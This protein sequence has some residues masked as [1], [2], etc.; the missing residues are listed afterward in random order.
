MQALTISYF[1]R[2]KMEIDLAGL[3]SPEWPEGF[4]PIAWRGDL[5]VTHADVLA[6]SFSNEMDAVIF[7]S[8]GT[9]HGCSG[10][11]QEMIKRRAFIPE[12]TWLVVGPSGPCGSVQALRERGSLGA[13]Q[14]VGI[15]PGQRG[16]HLGRALVLQALRGM[17]T[18]GLGRATL[19]V[20]A[21]NL[22][23]VQLYLGLGFR[24]TKVVYKAI[25]TSLTAPRPDHEI[26]DLLF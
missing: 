20:T 11:L 8:L 15:V 12:A 23:A 14:N 24:R 1:K 19:E 21:S 18:S 9:V 10:L 13:I 26:S 25:P 17:A 16:K 22:P 7:P 4:Y 3:A 2:Y 6:A 5:L